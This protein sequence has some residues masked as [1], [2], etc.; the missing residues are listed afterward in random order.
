MFSVA[1]KPVGAIFND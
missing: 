1:N